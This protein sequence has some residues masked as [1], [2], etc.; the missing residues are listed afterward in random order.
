M[1]FRSNY[2]AC[3]PCRGDR[4]YAFAQPECILSITLEQAQAAVERVLT[5]VP[6]S[7]A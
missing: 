7:V 6:S 4:C 1:L 5:P 2:Y 3:N